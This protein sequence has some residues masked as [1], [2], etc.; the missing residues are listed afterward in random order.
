MK[1]L[2][3]AIQLATIFRISVAPITTFST[4]KY[5]LYNNDRRPYNQMYRIRK[6]MLHANAQSTSTHLALSR[7]Q[8]DETA[9]LKGNETFF[10]QT[11][12]K[13]FH[14]LLLVLLVLVLLCVR[15]VPAGSK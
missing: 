1:K 13:S 4:I 12:Q 14:L 5:V 15:N 7:T 3:I 10:C 8:R 2:N 9:Q 11:K 6:I